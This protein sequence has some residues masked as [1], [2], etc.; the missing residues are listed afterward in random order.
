MEL[1]ALLPL[2]LLAA[3]FYLLILRPASK[4]QKQQR[5]TVAALT[6]GQEVMTASGIFGRVTAVSERRITI[7]IADGVDIEVL[8]A[9]ISQVVA[10]DAPE[11]A[12]DA[13]DDPDAYDVDLSKDAAPADDDTPT[14]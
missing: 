1:T 3:V 9:A 10:P 8:P 4:R 7:A 11:A 2:V 14:R 6:P 13:D 5:A 12:D